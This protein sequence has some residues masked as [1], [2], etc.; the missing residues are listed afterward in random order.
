[1]GLLHHANYLIYLEQ[2][3]TEMLRGARPGHIAIWK[4]KGSS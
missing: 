1:M 2:A 4:I 3:R